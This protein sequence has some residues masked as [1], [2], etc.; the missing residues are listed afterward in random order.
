MEPD[1]TALSQA[2]KAELKDGFE[3]FTATAVHELRQAADSNGTR[4]ALEAL[5]SAVGA[6]V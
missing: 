5:F 3:K 4:A 6:A 2:C 1:W